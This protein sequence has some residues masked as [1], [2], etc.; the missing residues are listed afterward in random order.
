LRLSATPNG[1]NHLISECRIQISEVRTVEAANSPLRRHF[2]RDTQARPQS[3]AKPG[4]NTVSRYGHTTRFFTIINQ[5]MP[6]RPKGRPEAIP[7]SSPRLAS[8][9]L[10]R[11]HL[12]APHHR[13]TSR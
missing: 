6:R 11:Q 13:T 2:A 1:K 10:L 8:R 7:N 9:R 3:F 12:S 4:R 5:H